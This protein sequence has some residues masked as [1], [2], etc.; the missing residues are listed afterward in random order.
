MCPL[1]NVRRFGL[2]NCLK[3]R[4]NVIV[5]ATNSDRAVQDDDLPLVAHFHLQRLMSS[6]GCLPASRQGDIQC[7]IQRLTREAIPSRTG[8]VHPFS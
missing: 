7:G 3:G 8:E 5:L 4:R 1:S 2:L 6:R